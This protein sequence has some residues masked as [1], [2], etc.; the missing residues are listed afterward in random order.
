MFFQKVEGWMYRN[1]HV[2]LDEEEK[3]RLQ[4]MRSVTNQFCSHFTHTNIETSADE[5]YDLSNLIKA[6]KY[7]YLFSSMINFPLGKHPPTT[8]F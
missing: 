8:N 3:K 6:A 4:N 2:F 5:R 7:I 1:L